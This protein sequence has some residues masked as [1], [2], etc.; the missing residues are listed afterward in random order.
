M[1][2]FSHYCCP[3]CG[4]TFRWLHH[5][6]D[7]PPPHFCPLCGSDMNAEPVFVPTAPHIGKTIG[8]T[9]DN[10][11]RQ[12]EQAGADHAQLAADLAGGEAADYAGLKVTDMPDYLRAGDIAAKLP[13]NTPVHQAMQAGQGGFGTSASGSQYLTAVTQGAFARRGDATRQSL[14]ATHQDR[15]RAMVGMGRVSREKG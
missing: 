13:Q 1:P 4:G 3:D 2:R 11:Y 14:A 5:P 15:V 7:E 9:A 8:R 10:I 6:V 12:M